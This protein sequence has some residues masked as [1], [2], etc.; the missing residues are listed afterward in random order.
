MDKHGWVVDLH[1]FEVDVIV[2]FNDDMLVVM[3]PVLERASMLHSTFECPGLEQSVAWAMAKSAEVKPGEVVLDP[4]CG[5]GIILLEA[6]QSW[7]EAC[8]L[9]FDVDASQLERSATNMRLL[10]HSIRAKISLAQADVTRIPLPSQSVDAVICDL[11]FGKQ[12]GSEEENEL[13]YPLAVSEFARV[14]RPESGR[15][16][17]LTNQS[18]SERLVQALQAQKGMWEVTCRR[19]LTLGNMEAVMFLARLSGD[20]AKVAQIPRESMRLPWEDSRGRAKWQSLR[21]MVRLPMQPVF[22]GRKVDRKT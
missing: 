7:R 11:P 12:W 16:V 13:L 4:M 9:G 1:S 6:A 10:S 3:L 8:Y 2:H 19:R 22:C 5:S 20:E 21:A 15:V 17:L 18:N 14:L